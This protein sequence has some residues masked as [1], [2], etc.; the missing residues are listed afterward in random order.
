[1]SAGEYIN[2]EYREAIPEPFWERSWRTFF[3]EKPMCCDTVFADRAAY[4]EHYV[5]MHLYSK[6]QP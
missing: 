4:E 1:M 3:R 5:R 2:G 6:E